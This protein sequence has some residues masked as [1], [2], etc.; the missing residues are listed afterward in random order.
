MFQKIS[1]M[2]ANIEQ[3]ALPIQSTVEVMT[4]APHVIS[5]DPLSLINNYKGYSYIC[6]QKNSSAVANANFKLYAT[7]AKGK[8]LGK[9][10]KTNNISKKRLDFIN[11]VKSIS[12]NEDVTEIVEHPFLDLIYSV[13]DRYD[14]YS[15]FEMTENYLGILGNCYWYVEKDG[16]GLPISNDI[17]P[18]E[19]VSIKFD[20]NNKIVGYVMSYNNVIKNFE[21][22]DI[23][24]FKNPIA[25][26]FIKLVT[27]QPL[28]N[29]YGFGNMEAVRDE[30]ELMNTINQYEISL[31]KNNARPDT[32]IAYK[33]KLQ[34]NDKRELSRMWNRLFKGVTNAGKVSISDGEFDIK[35]LNFNPKDLAYQD[36]K[37]YLINTICNAFGVPVDLIVTENSN[38]ASSA[39]AIEQYYK[40]TIQ[41]KLIKIQETITQSLLSSYDLNLF[42]MYDN[43]VPDNELESAT[44]DKTLVEAGIMTIEEARIKRGLQ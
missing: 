9:W 17:L 42:M 11:S 43:Q 27:N 37:K 26:S 13:N 44:I 36:G 29:V 23:I 6:Q 33:G 22:D 28:T 8:Q 25:G 20:S 10:V 16:E 40:F 32:V 38:R 2:F 24:H 35:P 4:Q 30:I 3:K 39:T 7:V 19:Y 14:K 12:S 5:R 41:P 1:K 34:D 21:K 15:L 18:S 31:L